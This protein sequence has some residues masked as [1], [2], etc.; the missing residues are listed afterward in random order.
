MEV[1]TK[2]VVKGHIEVF[3]KNRGRILNKKK[4]YEEQTIVI[5]VSNDLG[6][7]YRNLLFKDSGIL[8]EPPPFGCH[9]TLNNGKIKMDTKRHSEYLKDLNGKTI[10]IAIDVGI[11]RHWEFFALPVEGY[12]LNKIRRKL[13]LPYKDDFH[14]TVGRL[15]PHTKLSSILTKQI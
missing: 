2:V 11:Y 10:K 4:P 13:G 14:I 6:R 5:N 15:H 8:L 12:D 7:F 3:P 9:V 1:N